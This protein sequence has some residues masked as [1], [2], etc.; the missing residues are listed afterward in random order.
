MNLECSREKIRSAIAMAERATGKNLSLM[1]LSHIVLEADKLLLKIRATN[2]DLGLEISLPSK[3]NKT[4]TVAVSGQVL[5]NF[6]NNLPASE[7]KVKLELVNNNLNISSTNNST[8][9]KSYPIED[10]P[11]I[12]KIEKPNTFTISSNDVVSDLKQVFYSASS[13]NLKP[14]IASV[15]LYNQPDGLFFVATDSFRLAEKKILNQELKLELPYLIIPLKNIIELIRIF[16]GFNKDL[17]VEYNKHQIAFTAEHFYL[18][19][20]LVEGVFP[21]Y[22]Q[23]IPTKFSTKVT[24]DKNEL[25]KTLKLSN[26][27]TD[28]FN[29]ADITITTDGK[30]EIKTTNDFGDNS[31]WLSVASLEG[32]TTAVSLNLR[33]LID[34]LSVINSPQVTLGFSGLNKPILLSGLSDQ[35]FNYL[36]MPI[37]R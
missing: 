14:E 3:I 34:G 35:G 23:I 15:C 31:S 21:D 6:F 5:N 7:D 19:S 1:I 29:Q 2:L 11:L 32:E 37:R 27:F 33:Y 28:K 9:I 18:T 4:G 36:I 20:R 26:I 17:L 12:P 16:D 25:L 22:R 13:S 24:V 10:F 30:M 8:T